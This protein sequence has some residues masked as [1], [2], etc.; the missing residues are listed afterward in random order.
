MLRMTCG[1]SVSKMVQQ[2]HEEKWV[3]EAQFERLDQLS[4]KG[5]D[6]GY[7][8]EEDIES[9]DVRKHEHFQK[10]SDFWLTSSEKAVE[11]KPLSDQD[12]K[13]VE[14]NI[15]EGWFITTY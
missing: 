2:K 13:K 15:Y 14:R 5:N 12:L 6:Q 10:P 9:G 7:E 1:V 4:M 3:E 11:V 8:E